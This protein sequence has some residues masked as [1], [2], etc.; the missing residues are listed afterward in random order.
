MKIAD[1]LTTKSPITKDK[2]IRLENNIEAKQVPGKQ[3]YRDQDQVKLSLNATI[4]RAKEETKNLPLV[5][6]NKVREL[7]EKS[8][9]GTYQVSNRDLARAMIRFL[10]S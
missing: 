9:S 5:R 1:I 10:I 3:S 7:Q 8:N 6:E 4:E 2:E